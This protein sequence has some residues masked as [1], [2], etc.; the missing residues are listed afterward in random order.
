MEHHFSQARLVFHKT[1]DILR[2]IEDYHNDNEQTYREEE[3]PYIFFKY[4]P[5]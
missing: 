4:V 2:H 5:I 3:C 1:V